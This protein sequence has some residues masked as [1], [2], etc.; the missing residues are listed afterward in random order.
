MIFQIFHIKRIINDAKENPSG[1]A[2]NEAKDVLWGIVLIPLIIA[3]LGIILFFIIGYTHLLG[4]QFGFFKFL[5][6]LSLIVGYIIF[7]VIRRIIKS[8]SKSTTIHTKSVLKTFNL[9]NENK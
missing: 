2:G 9:E 6:W 7:S 5:F 1:L 3:I 4:F 8:V